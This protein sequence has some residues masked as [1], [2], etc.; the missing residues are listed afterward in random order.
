LGAAFRIVK[1]FAA[2]ETGR[3]FAR[4]R[5]LWEQLGHPSEFFHVPV[6]QVNYHS[7]RG[8]LDVA[9]RLNEELLRVSRDD[10]VGRLLAHTSLAQTLMFRGSFASSR[11]HFEQGLALHDP[12][13]RRLLVEWAARVGRA[14]GISRVSAHGNLGI[15]RFCLGYPD[16]ALAEIEAMIAEARRLAHPPY[17]VLSQVFSAILLSL[18]GDIAALDRQA[19]ALASAAIEQ[20]FPLYGAQGAI[21]LGWAKVKQGDVS[22]GMSL[23]RSGS[24]AYRATGSQVWMPHYLALLATASEIAGQKEEAAALLHDALHSVERTGERWF[25]AELNRHKGEVLLRQ[26]HCEVAEELFR[27]A[28]SIAQEQQARLWE[29]RAAVSLARLRRDQG[30]HAD[31]RAILTPIYGWFTE[32]FNTPDLK[33]AKALLDELA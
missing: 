22:E 8:E 19:N 10:P 31:A 26:G 18:V 25:E 13:A 29:L 32:G 24:G 33:E 30:R 17:L 28:M 1:G 20:G 2:P 4:A 6:G 23:L 5:E 14:Q 15:V 12:I 27:K 11:S 9:L 7:L 21:F 16:Q 3:A